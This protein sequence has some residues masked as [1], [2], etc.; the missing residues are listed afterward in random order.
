MLASFTLLTLE[1]GEDLH[2]VRPHRNRKKVLLKFS[3][4]QKAAGA[5]FQHESMLNSVALYYPSMIAA[6]A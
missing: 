2:L 5:K 6:G 1:G 3:L 4:H